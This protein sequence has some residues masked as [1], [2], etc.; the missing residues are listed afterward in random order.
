MLRKILPYVL[1]VLLVMI[2]LS[3][4]PV[5]TDSVYL[6]PLGADFRDVHRHAAGAHARHALRASWADCWWTFWRGILWDI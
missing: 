4:I 5:F 3:V 6:L 2:D 1:V